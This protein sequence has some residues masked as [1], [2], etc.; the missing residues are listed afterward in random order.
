MDV[1]RLFLSFFGCKGAHSKKHATDPCKIQ[2]YLDPAFQVTDDLFVHVLSFI[3]AQELANAVEVNRFWRKSADQEALW[4]DL[5]CSLWPTKIIQP[6]L[7]SGLSWRQKYGVAIQDG[8]RHEITLEDLCRLKSWTVR[9]TDRVAGF[10]I[11]EYVITDYPFRPDYTY[12]S[13]SFNYEPVPWEFHEEEGVKTG[14][15]V[16]QNGQILVAYIKRTDD[17]GWTLFATYGPGKIEWIA[18]RQ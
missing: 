17:W 10:V 7:P 9:M 16:E 5:C 18:C 8:R 4:E 1:Q 15:Q 13:P 6:V 3:S 11:R 14:L 2:F 12:V